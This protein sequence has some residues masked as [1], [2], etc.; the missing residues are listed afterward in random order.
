[1][2]SGLNI[3]RILPGSRRWACRVV[4]EMAAEVECG[5]A[6]AAALVAELGLLSRDRLC[7]LLPILLPL[8]LLCILFVY[9]AVCRRIPRR[10][11]GVDAPARWIKKR[12]VVASLGLLSHVPAKGLIDRPR[13]CCALSIFSS[14]SSFCS[15]L[16]AFGPCGRH[17]HA[18]FVSA[19]GFCREASFEVGKKNG[20][21]P[22]LESSCP[23]DQPKL[24]PP[25]KK[26]SRGG[27]LQ[28]HSGPSAL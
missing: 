5:V 11:A 19:N 9:I 10:N 8:L 15:L 4:V 25:E 22:A 21:P 16:Q 26:N 28:H 3:L 23:R 7:L 17:S 6:V 2:L 24:L 1:M 27:P 13:P 14:V 18:R 12:S 20:I